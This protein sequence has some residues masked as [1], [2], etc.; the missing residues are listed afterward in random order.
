[1][2]EISV[3]NPAVRLKSI[4]DAKDR[5]PI[6]R[7][8]VWIGSAFLKRAGL[9]DTLDNH[10]RLATQL[11]HDMVCLSVSEEPHDNRSLG[12]RYFE[13]RELGP[14]LRERTRF[15][16]AVIDGP[17][18]RM[19][20]KKGMM[21][22][23]MNWIRDRESTL[24]AYVAEQKIV[25]NLIGHVL[26][27]GV[28]G[29]VLAD[30]LAGEQAPLINPLDLDKVC[31]PFYMQAV[32]FIRKAGVLV[33]L[34]CCGNLQQLL[35]LLKSWNLDGLAAIQIGKNDLGLLDT[36][37]GGLFLAGID[38]T[39]LDANV[40]SPDEMEALK[41]FVAQFA[42]QKRLILCSNCG[43]Y[44]ADFLERVQ[45]IYLELRSISDDSYR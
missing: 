29:I 24:R 14:A 42:E 30:D 1:M 19:V 2:S 22:V 5:Y 25:L 17:F 39:L 20:N 28:D 21:D 18:Q 15:L 4:M 8:E 26:E 41:R 31:T 12:Y 11:G 13:P 32:P 23:L 44:K 3:Q 36:E 45:H 37:L 38:A 40:P 34:H 9:D 27:K 33:F 16:V 7:G 35:P 43:L 6:P 10:F